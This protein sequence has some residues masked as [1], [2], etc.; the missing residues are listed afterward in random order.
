MRLRELVLLLPASAC[1]LVGC[2][3]VTE[4]PCVL[5]YHVEK[6]EA[7]TPFKEEYVE[8]RDGDEAGLPIDYVKD[9]KKLRDK[10]AKTDIEPGM[11][12]VESDWVDC[13]KSKTIVFQ[14]DLIE[15]LKLH[16]VAEREKKK[17]SE[18]AKELLL[19]KLGQ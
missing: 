19:R 8:L 16:T 12:A 11:I 1:L 13:E 9:L 18:F 6:V 10:V 2:A 15:M 17:Y 14:T 5:Y 3:S 7:G 4:K